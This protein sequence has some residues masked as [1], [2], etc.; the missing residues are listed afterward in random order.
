MKLYG[1]RIFVDNF[2]AAQAFYGETLG[3]KANWSMPEIGAAGFDVGTAELIV[4]AASG[5][6]RALV[7]RFVGVSLQVDD[8]DAAYRSMTAKGVTFEQPP[9]KQ[10]W[11]GTLAHFRDPSGNILTLLG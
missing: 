8:I 4:E 2:A 3:L 9:E 11:G 6:D 10:V 1:V 7:G 5:K